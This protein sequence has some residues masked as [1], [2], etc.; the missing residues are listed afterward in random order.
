[1][2]EL[3]PLAERYL[4]AV[5]DVPPELRARKGL[6]D[7]LASHL[8]AGSQVCIRG[9]WRIGKTTL[10]KGVLQRAC[11]RSNGAAL[12]FDVRDPERE[13]GLPQSVEAVLQRLSVKVT[14][15]LKA[16]GAI[17]L[18]VDVK[19]PLAVLGELAAPIFV[20][21]DELIALSALPA[22]QVLPVLDLLLNTPR[23]VRVAVVAHRH[24]DVDA[25]FDTAIVQ[26]PGVATCFVPP[27]ADDELVTLVNTPA[28]A[29]NVSFSNEALGAI[30]E[31]AGNR[32]WEV[33]TF[34]ALAAMKLPVGFTGEVGPEA[35]EALVNLDTLTEVEEGRALVD[36]ALRTLV[37]ALTPAEKTLLELLAVGGEGEVP[38]DAV[39]ALELAGFITTTDGY[40]INGALFAGIVQGVAEGAIKVA[41][42]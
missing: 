32:P 6:E 33:V 22:E 10:L 30:A 9:F 13:D 14:E 28:A 19:S 20:G 38:E 24:R 8:T 16:V 11:E 2:S 7:E 3:H 23:N 4:D 27:I 37:T 17:D 1:M 40:A 5:Y 39:A 35:I 29:F 21:L 41:V 34:C 31:V 12:L 36:N 18:K 42:E 15:F 26:R 25:L